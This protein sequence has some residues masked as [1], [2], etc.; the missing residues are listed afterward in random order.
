VMS[1]PLNNS[2]IIDQN[3]QQDYYSTGESRWFH[4]S[5][6]VLNTRLLDNWNN[7]V[8][9][10]YN[11][12]TGE[13]PDRFVQKK[14]EHTI[15]ERLE[16]RYDGSRFYVETGY[17]VLNEDYEL[18][19][20]QLNLDF[21]DHYQW[22]TIV[23]YDLNESLFKKTVTSLAV[24]YNNFGYETAAELDLNQSEVIK[25]DNKL[26][27]EFGPEEWNWHLLLNSS[28][29]FERDELDKAEISVE[30]RLHCR[31][32]SLAYDHSSEEIWFQYQILAFPGGGV[33]F[34]S[35]EEE[36][37]LFDDDLGGILDDLD[38]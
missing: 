16:W 34:G 9:H 27:W 13:A 38:E 1:A 24:D 28:Y 10:N 32:I 4:E 18:L 14:E 8:T 21:K 23:A 31:S 17:D 30:K 36:G 20:S 7:K 5:R 19:K 15:D 12:G 26:D 2:V 29:D 25:W 33:K 11:F 3:F 22:D 35:N 6:L 37:M